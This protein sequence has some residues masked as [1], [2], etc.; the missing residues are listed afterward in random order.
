[1]YPVA[2]LLLDYLRN[3]VY[4]P[5]SAVLDIDKLPEELQE[6]GKGLLYFSECIP[7][8]SAL[9]KALSKGNLNVRLPAPDNEIAA[10]LKALHA[11][12]KHLT[13]QTQQVAKGDYQQRVDFM[14]DFSEAFNVMTEQLERQRSA[15]LEEI[16]T[17][18]QNKSLYELLMGQI[19]QWII[20]TDAKTAEW[21]F[22]S[23]ELEDVLADPGCEQQLRQWLIMQTAKMNGVNEVCTK[24][25]ELFNNIGCQYYS[26]SIHPL[27]WHRHNAVAF[28]LTDVSKERERLIRLQNI[29][30]YDTL[31]QVYNRHYGM[32]VLEEWIAE[33]RSF[34]LCFADIDNLKF[35][36][37]NFG[38]LEGDRYI[39]LVT[40]I[41]HE[42]SP[43]AVIC[44]MGG[45]EFM[46]LAQ[47]WD[48][49]AA[50]E[51][52]ELLRSRLAGYKNPDTSYDHSIS[53]GVIPVD[54]DNTLPA[55]DL[56]YAADE[57]MYEYKRAYKMM[58]RRKST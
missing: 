12:L 16:H 8:A 5:E 19:P 31:T 29:C 37:D 52:L 41:L 50:I 51:Q 42:F 54:P 38:H 48:E 43:D 49:D 40:N 1:M 24:E 57:K 18:I 4:H 58:R 14:G 27:H 46:L 55:S 28:V 53:Y 11:A 13:W 35:V 2:K 15:L 17:L 21:L 39:L 3:V 23:Q 45:D 9:A 6:F 10:P 44:R 36:N 47:G 22:I 34:I 20:V 32:E 7:E 30:N 26:V 25:L 33:S 56:L